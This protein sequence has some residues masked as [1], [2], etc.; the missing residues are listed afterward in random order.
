[1]IDLSLFSAFEHLITTVGCLMIV[2]IVDQF[3]EICGRTTRF[4]VLNKIAQFSSL[5]MKEN[6]KNN[7]DE[8]EQIEWK[9]EYAS[10]IIR[11]ML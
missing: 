10:I 7:N 6:V 11:P 1:M 8:G 9:K 2:T 3:E 5:L 4:I